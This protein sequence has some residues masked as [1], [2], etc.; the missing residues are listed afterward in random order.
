MAAPQPF[1]TEPTVPLQPSAAAGA[2]PAIPAVPACPP[3]QNVQLAQGALS[4]RAQGEGPALLFLH[5]LLGSSKSWAFQY[6]HFAASHRVLGWDAPG[7]GESSLVPAALDSYVAALQAFVDG[8]ALRRVALVGHSMG[9]AVAARFAARQPQRVSCLVLSCTHPGYAEP[10]TAPPSAKFESRM[11]ELRELG[12][13]SYGHN[14]ARDLL[15]APS[16]SAVVDYA[17]GIA[18]ETNPEGL[19]RATRMLQL[20]DNRALLPTLSMPVLVLTGEQDRVVQPRLEADLLRLTPY[21]RHVR[22]PGVAHAPYL[23]APQAYNR[24]IAEFLLSSPAP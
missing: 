11:R 20:A 16:A 23:Q 24:L 15:P 5:G 1:N 6:P 17:A 22:M 7:F 2:L 3:L 21:T 9:G 13:R 8:L 4:Y 14:R 10:A 12:P 18:A 19:R